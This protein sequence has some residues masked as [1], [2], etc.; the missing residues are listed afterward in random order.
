MPARPTWLI[1]VADILDRL[2]LTGGPPF[3]DRAAIEKLF[4]VSR[5]QAIRLMGACRGYEVGRTFLVDRQSV[6][7]F[8]EQ[9]EDSG[10]TRQA[11]AR[12]RRVLAAINEVADQAA[13]RRVRIAVAPAKETASIVL[14]APGKLEITFGSAEELL[15]HIASIAGA[16]TRDFSA[17]RKRYE[18]T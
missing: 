10:A 4:C 14:S 15:T 5:R 1:R 11:D 2:R 18:G 13:A 7:E 8:L 16:A 17:F 12:K 9:I 3:L 6:I